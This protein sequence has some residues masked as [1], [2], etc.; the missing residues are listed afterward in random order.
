MNKP[1]LLKSYGY[2]PEAY[3]L[4]VKLSTRIAADN[5]RTKLRVANVAER[6]RFDEAKRCTQPWRGR[7]SDVFKKPG[8]PGR[9]HSS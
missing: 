4:T 2:L 3:H 1:F 8:P 6:G 9:T 5:L 7:R